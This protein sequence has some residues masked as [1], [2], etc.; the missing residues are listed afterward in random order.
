MESIQWKECF[1]RFLG[2]LIGNAFFLVSLYVPKP[3]VAA[4]SALNEK[5]V[6]AVLEQTQTLTALWAQ[7]QK[8]NTQGAFLKTSSPQNVSSLVSEM[9]KVAQARKKRLEALVEGNPQAVLSLAFTSKERDRYPLEVQEFLEEQREIEGVL[10]VLVEDD[11]SNSKSRL[12]HYLH[13]DGERLSLHFAGPIPQ[14][15]SGS[16]VEITGIKVGEKV[17]LSVE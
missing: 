2:A 3:L 8:K 7:F 6:R 4:E 11:F 17:A 12:L 13:A 9:R 15:L 5:E 14:V 16:Q 1:T 10:E